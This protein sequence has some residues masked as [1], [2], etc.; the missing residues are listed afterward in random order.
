M[1]VSVSGRKTVTG[2]PAIFDPT[3]TK[4]TTSARENRHEKRQTRCA[5]QGPAVKKHRIKKLNFRNGAEN[6][7]K[8]LVIV[9]KVHH[10]HSN[11]CHQEQA[12]PEESMMSMS[13]SGGPPQDRLATHSTECQ[14]DLTADEIEY[15][16]TE[17]DECRKKAKILEEKLE[18]KKND[19]KESHSLKTC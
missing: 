8:N 14:T 12:I 2:Y 13:L 7:K 11:L 3:S 6:C 9:R 19:S 16:I 18:N 1:T 17:L 10:D 15:L 5:N 4:T